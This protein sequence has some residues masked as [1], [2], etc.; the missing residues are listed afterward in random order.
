MVQV[1]KEC[2]SIRKSHKRFQ[3]MYEEYGRYSDYLFPHER[4]IDMPRK[5]V[6]KAK[7]KLLK[8]ANIE[9]NYTMYDLRRTFSTFNAE[10][11]MSFDDIAQFIGHT[12]SRTTKENCIHTSVM[13][14]RDGAER[15]SRILDFVQERENRRRP[16]SIRT[17]IYTHLTRTT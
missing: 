3:H 9:M 13:G 17:R 10:Q 1:I 15:S 2:L 7:N 6:D 14:T 12:D 4:N 16:L 11:G 8:V 5:T